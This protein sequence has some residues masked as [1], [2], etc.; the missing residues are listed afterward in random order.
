MARGNGKTEKDLLLSLIEMQRALE[1]AA[2]TSGKMIGTLEALVEAAGRQ[3][4]EIDDLRRH[5]R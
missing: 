5:C 1:H 3:D 4:A 2:A